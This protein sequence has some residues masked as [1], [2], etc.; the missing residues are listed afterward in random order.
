MRPAGMMAQPRD[1]RRRPRLLPPLRC[2]ELGDGGRDLGLEPIEQ[3]EATSQRTTIGR[4][5]E[6][7]DRLVE[8]AADLLEHS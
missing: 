1:H 8:S 7:L 6:F 4:D 2:I 5:V 3:L